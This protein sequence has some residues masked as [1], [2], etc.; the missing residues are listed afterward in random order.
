MIKSLEKQFESELF[1]LEKSNSE[2]EV[3]LGKGDIAPQC[4]GYSKHHLSTKSLK[5]NF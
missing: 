3:E 2:S 5:V 4:S 1:L